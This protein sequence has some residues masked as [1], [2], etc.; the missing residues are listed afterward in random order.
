M[1]RLSSRP[2]LPFRRRLLAGLLV[3][4]GLTL[5]LARPAAAEKPEIFPLSEVKRG[6][7]GYGMTTFAG[8]APERFEF[9]VVGVLDNMLPGLDIIIVKSEDPKLAVTGWWAGSSG[10]PLYIDGKLLCAF[11]YGWRFTKYPIG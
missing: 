11:S 4:G 6:L 10:S 3:L 7:K 9:E 8:T 5:V 1:D 2:M